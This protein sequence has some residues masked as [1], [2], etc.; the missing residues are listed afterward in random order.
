MQSF[1]MILMCGW[2]V[3]PADAAEWSGKG[4]FGFVMARGNSETET[5]NLGLQFERKSEKW[6][7]DLKLT[8]LRASDE[9]ELNAERYTLGYKSGYNFNAKS[10]LFGAI[11][12]DQDEFSSN[13]YQASLSIGYGRQLLDTD[14]QQLSVEIGP[15]VRRSEPNDPLRKTETNV[16]GRLSSGYAWTISETASLTNDLLVEAGSDNTFAENEL[17]LNVAINS[18]FALKLSG[19]VRHNT[20]VDPGVE[21]TDTLTTANLVYKFGEQ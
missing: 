12:Y 14:S 11:R 3:C 2:L 17:A 10:Y 15:G 5:L 19:A 20:D 21:K 16:I 8:A 9:G 6:R 18:R 13:D 7:N 1:A 4:E